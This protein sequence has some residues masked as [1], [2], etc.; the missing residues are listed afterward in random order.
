MNNKASF[1]LEN[2]RFEKVNI[3]L[4]NLGEKR[5]SVDFSPSGVYNKKSGVFSLS[6]LF[7]AQSEGKGNPFVEIFCTAEHKFEEPLLLEDIPP[8]FYPNSIAILFPYIRAFV[9]TVTL[10]AN[11]QPLILPTYNLSSLESKLKDNTTQTEA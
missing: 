2:Y 5:L 4:D 3:N 11:I 6:F 1:S 9:S 8:F 10:Q 7:I